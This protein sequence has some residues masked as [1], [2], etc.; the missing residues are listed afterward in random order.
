M[1]WKQLS[2]VAVLVGALVGCAND[3]AI[4][5]IAPLSAITNQ[6]S[7][8][9]L[10]KRQVGSGVGQFYSHLTPVVAYDKVFAADRAGEVVALD[11]KT[12]T[13]IWQVKAQK[14][15][16]R[17]ISGGLVVAFDKVFFGTETGQLTALDA[18]TGEL[19]W[20]TNV[21]GEILAKPLAAESMLI[22]HNSRGELAA[23]SHED[24]K[25]VWKI[26]T[27]VPALTL[28]GDSSPVAVSGAAFWGMANGRIGAALLQNGNM[29]WQLPV[30]TPRGSTEIERLVDVDAS[31]LIVGGTLFAVGYNGKLIAV[32][33]QSGSLIWQRPYS[34]T[35]NFIFNDKTIYLVTD[36]DVLVAVDARSG[37]ELWKNSDLKYRQLTMPAIVDG[38]L[39]VGDKKGY[40]HWVDVTNG[41]FVARQSLKGGGLAVP[42]LALDDGVLT[43]TRDGVLRKQNLPSAAQMTAEKSKKGRQSED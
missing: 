4:V 12:G 7:P 31:P 23:Y 6:F 30:A 39:A 27:D 16:P 5:E 1:G 19:L 28:R 33:L 18:N 8:Q 41:E 37:S 11:P 26:A 10:W 13:P 43:I 25:L 2:A 3:D 34:A 15:Q 21:E 20:Q 14:N 36:K 38:Y 9:F 17:Y 22:V 40:L 24:G 29:I 42:P 32:D 35:Q